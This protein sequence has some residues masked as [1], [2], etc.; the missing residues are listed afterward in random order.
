MEE[1]DDCWKGT[2]DNSATNAVI[3]DLMLRDELNND[4]VI[5]LSLPTGFWGTS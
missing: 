5:A 3:I 1:A 2:F 4:V